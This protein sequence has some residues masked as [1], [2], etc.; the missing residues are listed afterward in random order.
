MLLK[1]LLETAQADIVTE[2]QEAA[3]G[4]IK[5][6]LMQIEELEKALSS[7]RS[8]LRQLLEMDIKEF[9]IDVWG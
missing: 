8:D 6:R 7:A 5:K 2:K 4:A 9:D 1:E 3:V